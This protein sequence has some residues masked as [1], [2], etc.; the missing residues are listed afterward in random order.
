MWDIVLIQETHLRP[1]EEDQLLL[2]PGYTC[3]AMSRPASLAFRH[4]GGGLI[5]IFPTSLGVANITPTPET[6]I[7]LL[8]VL[9]VTV[10]NVYLP[11]PNSPWQRNQGVPPEQ[12][13]LELLLVEAAED[14]LIL[15]GDFNARVGD[16]SRV[17]PRTSPDTGRVNTRGSHILRLCDDLNLD[18]VNG[19]SWQTAASRNRFTS[20][21]P[22]GST[23]IDLCILSDSLLHDATSLG[24][25]F[26]VM[27]HDPRWPDHTPIALR[28]PRRSA[29][30]QTGNHSTPA[31]R[32]I[33]SARPLLHNSPLSAV[34]TAVD[35]IAANYFPPGD[36]VA[37]IYGCVWADDHPVQVRCA[38]QYVVING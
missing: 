28:L 19:S 4:Q 24:I 34:D 23:V 16:P 9:D 27:E 13:L 7:M 33:R 29:Q 20:Y 6:E 2:P 31:A 36:G 18:I 14:N 37:R 3:V 32:P 22:L 10:A 5:A 25:Q 21:Q 35:N 38:T 15:M 26:T 8:R 11:P 30:L 1:G 17:L 12:H